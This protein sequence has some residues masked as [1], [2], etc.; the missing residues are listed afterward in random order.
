MN[1][2]KQAWGRE[3]QEQGPAL[4]QIEVM[5]QWMQKHSQWSET[6]TG[7]I[8][9]A[10][11]RLGMS[12][13]AQSMN[14]SL[15]QLP[16]PRSEV[17]REQMPCWFHVPL[18]SHPVSSSRGPCTHWS[19]CCTLP[20]CTTTKHKHTHARN[21]NGDDVF[22]WAR[23]SA[24]HTMLWPRGSFL[25]YYHKPYSWCEHKTSSDLSVESVQSESRCFWL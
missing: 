24:K 14:G 19:T 11:F 1:K 7:I 2:F 8:C 6:E 12:R 22:A 25:F 23:L 18:R 9:V 10:F 3:I 21:D 5:F 20:A 17:K 13:K 15:P 16:C 4:V